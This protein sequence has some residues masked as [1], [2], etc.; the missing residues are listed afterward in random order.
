M[1][2]EM[3]VGNPI[4]SNGSYDGL[5]GLLQENVGKSYGLHKYFTVTYV[6]LEGRHDRCSRSYGF[7]AQST[8]SNR[9]SC[10]HIRGYN[11]IRGRNSHSK[12]NRHW[13][14]VQIL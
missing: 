2:K 11:T 12:D 4:G 6:T 13:L 3:T 10:I 9:T 7:G 14:H 8:Y 5:I 1:S